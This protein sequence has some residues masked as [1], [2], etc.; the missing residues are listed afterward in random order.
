MVALKPVV[1][2]NPLESTPSQPAMVRSKSGRASRRSANRVATADKAHLRYVAS[3]PCLVCGRSPADA[4]HLRFTQPRA[5]ERKNS[6]EFTVPL[7]EP[8]TVT[9]IT[10]GTKSPG[11]KDAPSI[12]SQRRGRSGSRPIISNKASINLAGY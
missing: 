2:V 4:H 10:A 5:M 11:G 12:L 8:I 3:Q 7:A 9:T 6:D 1:D